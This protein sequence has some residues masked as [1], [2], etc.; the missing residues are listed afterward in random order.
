ME[1]KEI[2]KFINKEEKNFKENNNYNKLII[3]K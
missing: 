1:K 3:I 2:N